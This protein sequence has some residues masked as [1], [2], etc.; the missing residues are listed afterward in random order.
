[1]IGLN[2]SGDKGEEDIMSDVGRHPCREVVSIWTREDMQQDREVG[3][4]SDFYSSHLMGMKSWPRN[5]TRGEV[6]SGAG[7]ISGIQF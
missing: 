3:S 1:M 6:K 2:Q 5:W 4:F 7:E